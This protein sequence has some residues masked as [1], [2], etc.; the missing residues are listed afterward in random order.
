MN[1]GTAAWMNSAELPSLLVLQLTGT[2][3]NNAGVV[4]QRREFST[5]RK[6]WLIQR[7]TRF[8]GI[9]NFELN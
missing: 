4:L 6:S 1:P 7:I 3:W 5:H 8:M 9:P 2:G